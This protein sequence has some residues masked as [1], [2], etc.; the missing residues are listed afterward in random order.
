[1]RS[2]E[3]ESTRRGLTEGQVKSLAMRQLFYSRLSRD[4]LFF[5]ECENWSF[6]QNNMQISTIRS[7]LKDPHW[8][9]AHTLH[10]EAKQSL[11]ATV[12]QW[13]SCHNTLP[14]PAN[15]KLVTLFILNSASSSVIVWPLS[16]IVTWGIKKINKN[17]MCVCIQKKDV[18]RNMHSC[19]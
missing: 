9:P 5:T 14:K 18:Y 4:C 6:K 12:R 10:S 3:L 13:R 8:N 2:S 19:K 15:F 17:Q 11:P 7:S 1:M 16:T